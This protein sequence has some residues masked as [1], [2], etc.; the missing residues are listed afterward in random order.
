MTNQSFRSREL[1]NLGWSYLGD[2]V[3][4]EQLYSKSCTYI[5]AK[6]ERVKRGPGAWRHVDVPGFWSWEAELPDEPWVGVDLPH[7]FM[8]S[9]EPKQQYCESDGFFRHH[10]AWYRRHF[11]VSPE[12]ASRRI[13]LYIEGIT[14]LSELYL[15]GCYLCSSRSSYLPIEA[16]ITDL[17]RF[18]KE[19]VLAVHV[20]SDSR[21]GWWYPGGGM[22]RNVWL[23]KMPL[24]HIA[25]WGVHVPVEHLG[26][27]KWSLPVHLTLNNQSDTAEE[28]QALCQLLE[29][30]GTPVR[31][32]VI[33]GVIGA[34]ESG[35]FHG[36]GEMESPRLW[37][38]DDPQMYVMRVTLR[39]RCGGG[40]WEDCDQ[41]EQ[42]FGFR[43][44]RFTANEGFFLNGRNVKIQGV[45]LHSDYG[46]SGKA[47]PDN[48]C[49]YRM[50]LI[51]ATGANALRCSHYPH[52]EAV[53]AACDRMGILVLDE[54][55]RF[56]SNSEALRDM[57]TLV[58]RDRNH[59]SVFMW[60]TCNEEMDYHGLEQ[61]RRIQ[62]SLAAAIRRHDKLRPITMAITNL[63]NSTVNQE[64]DVVGVNYSFKHIDR[65]RGE[66]P[67]QPYLSTENCAIG[68]SRGW[69]DGDDP[70][71]GRVDSRDNDPPSDSFQVFNRENTWKYI[72]ERP[73]MAGG[74]QWICVDHRG[75]ARWPRISSVSGS[76]DM[77]L[78]KK[79]AFYQC[80]SF[81]TKEPMVHLLP[82]WNHRGLEGSTINVRAYSNCPEV[83]LFLNGVSC[84]RRAL[85]PCD[86]GE[87]EI[88]YAPGR[89]EAVGYR[90]GAEVARDIQETTGEAVALELQQENQDFKANGVDFA[91]FTCVAKDAQGH[92]V[93]DAAPLVTFSCSGDATLVGTGSS[94]TDHVPVSS[95]VRQM[96]MGRIAVAIRMKAL[97]EGRKGR[98]V[99][100]A[101]A[102]GLATAKI[103]LD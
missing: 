45:C 63:H 91:I 6:T 98:V 23:E 34:R 59:P 53:M 2:V 67:E 99:L 40:T 17:V 3:P 64:C 13:V 47:V 14:G 101:R 31:E 100:T 71:L 82:H 76:Y 65:I 39:H 84:G 86:H 70:V 36:E 51:K 38:I 72:M 79:D 20:N 10:D 74:F 87:W 37:D 27:T 8:V 16:D 24:F 33:S 29:T 55:R 96:Y 57:E 77:F 52:Q 11:T 73:W 41:F 89:I 48:V 46:L 92:E 81:W 50:S 15:N 30:D 26:G 35:T 44:V 43:E 19:N 56:E 69:Y 22:T 88:Q 75:E 9:Q 58:L 12:D 25:R 54:N 28:F 78:Q 85:K 62:R 95:P 1:L 49:A 97:A 66:H 80:R 94:N 5:S 61:G 32:V 4:D 103:V 90:D 93:P 42:S 18:D 68:S 83:E 102:N 60:S 7:D 21:E